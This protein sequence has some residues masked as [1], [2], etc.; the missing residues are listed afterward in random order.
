M[1]A[2]TR[3][4]PHIGARARIQ[5]FGGDVVMG[6]VCVV[7]EGGRRVEVS[8]ESGER[9]EFVLSPATAKFVLVGAAHGAEMEL[10]ACP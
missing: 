3:P 1:L 9:M 4:L 10:L 2:P 7:G 6:T 8:C 5:H